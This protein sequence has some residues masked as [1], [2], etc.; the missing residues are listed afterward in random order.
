M[1]WM[2]KLQASPSASACWRQ[3]ELLHQRRH[4][5]LVHRHVAPR[6]LDFCFRP[7][8]GPHACWIESIAVQLVLSVFLFLKA[9]RAKQLAWVNFFWTVPPAVAAFLPFL[10]ATEPV[11]S[12]TVL[13]TLHHCGSEE[14]GRSHSAANHTEQKWLQEEY[15][16]Y[17]QVC[18]ECRQ[19]HP[20]LVKQMLTLKD[21][22]QPWR[23]DGRFTPSSSLREYFSMSV[24]MLPNANALTIH[25]WRLLQQQTMLFEI[26]VFTR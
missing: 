19:A 5:D 24:R 12:R 11:A 20:Q 8:F 22:I 14:H 2:K 6:S 18:A 23:D 4:W 3:I 26:S 25:T 17:Q 21:D 10:L 13:I 16:M 15:F 7:A 9:R 1:H